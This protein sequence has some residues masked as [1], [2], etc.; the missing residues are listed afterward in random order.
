[1]NYLSKSIL[2]I[3]AGCAMSAASVPA[4]AHAHQG[5]MSHEQRV[6][7][8]AERF[9][10]RQAALHD[11]LKLSPAQAGAWSAYQAAIKPAA[12]PARGER[13]AMAA[14]TAPERMQRRVDAGKRRLARMESRMAAVS[15]F[16]AQLTPEQKKVFD[17]RTAK[18]RQHGKHHARHHA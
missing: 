13:K 2:A 8:K 3:V 14:L 7:H 12:R 9:E 17:E 18:R 11:A 1:M 10:A 6:A 5:K 16:Y 15:S 4:L